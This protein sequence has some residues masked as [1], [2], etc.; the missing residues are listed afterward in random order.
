MEKKE[1]LIQ[2][3]MYMYCQFVNKVEMNWILFA[4]VLLILRLCLEKNIKF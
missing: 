2:D 3:F 1:N 4:V